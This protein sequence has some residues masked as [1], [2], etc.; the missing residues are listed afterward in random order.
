MKTTLSYFPGMCENPAQE[1]KKQLR[2]FSWTLRSWD[3]SFIIIFS[4]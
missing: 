4:L 1:V 3:E 2:K